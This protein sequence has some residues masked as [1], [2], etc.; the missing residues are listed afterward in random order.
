VNRAARVIPDVASFSVDD[1]FWYLVPDHLRGDLS[2]G[3]IVRVPLSGRRV[4]GWVVEVTE[5]HAGDLKEVAGISGETPVFDPA[6][7]ETL[8]WAA[9]HYVAPMSTLLKR[10]TPPN[11]PHLLPDPSRG[12]SQVEPGSPLDP[13]VERSVSGLGGPTTALVANWHA[14]DW[15]SSC[16][17]LL[18]AGKS[19]LVIVASVA[20]VERIRDSTP[21][22]M[23]WALA[24]VTGENDASDTKAWGLAQS[25]PRLIIGTPK[26]ALW[27]VR[28]LGLAV[29]LEEGRRAMKDRQTPTLHVRDV[30][31]TRTRVEGFNL[32]F[33]G[34]TPSVELLAAGAEVVRAGNRAWP[35]VEVVDRGEDPPGSGY[36]SDR[37]MA[38]IG[39]TVEKGGGVFVYTHRRAAYSSLRCA[40]CRALRV[41]EDCGARLGRVERCP[42]CHTTAGGCRECGGTEFEELGTIPERLVSEINRRI[43]PGIASTD[44]GET[45]V[46]VGTERDLAG[47][48]Q[49]TL[50][51]GADLDGML[52]GVGYRTSEEALRQLAR[53]GALVA[54][55]AGS[56]LVVQTSRPE[57]LLVTTLRRGDPIPY[58]ERVLVERAREGVPPSSEMIVVELRGHVPETV[59][60]DLAD[61]GADVVVYGPISLDDGR[62][63]LLTGKLGRARGELRKMVGR[64]RDKGATVRIDADPI[65]V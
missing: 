7:L 40:R 38:A 22:D 51:V 5:D 47:A 60:V 55:G 4:R 31:R 44:R 45:P 42:K 15:L 36:L 21:R 34:P 54:P 65:D 28:D 24:A 39:A 27:M 12:T 11:L 29:V 56:R 2:V 20:E 16:G 59:V 43:G 6:L 48:G 19:V 53:L 10:A 25:P 41:C 18:S 1:G 8:T 52:M 3:S 62:R 14:L 61:L 26:T 9:R 64:W 50:A 33:F 13:M 30:M 32:V 46:M 23:R 17:A 35:L 63:W 58:L 37:V 49:V 57:S